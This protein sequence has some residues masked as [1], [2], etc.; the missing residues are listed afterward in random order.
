MKQRRTGKTILKKLARSVLTTSLAI[1]AT[2]VPPA[3]AYSFAYTVADMRLPF[4]QSGGNA[5]PQADHWNSSLAG[6]INR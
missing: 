5:C 3:Q 2:M 4:A 1:Y 6:G